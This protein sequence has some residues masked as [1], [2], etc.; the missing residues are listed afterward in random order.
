MLFDQM[1]WVGNAVIGQM[2]LELL[3]SPMFAGSLDMGIFGFL[4]RFAHRCL[5]S[6][7]ACLLVL[8][9]FHFRFR[10]RASLGFQFQACFQA[11]GQSI[12]DYYLEDEVRPTYKTPPLPRKHDGFSLGLEPAGLILPDVSDS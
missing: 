3:R 7:A 8:A 9:P 2:L 1:G 4:V 10:P 12:R 6:E 5:M 11:N